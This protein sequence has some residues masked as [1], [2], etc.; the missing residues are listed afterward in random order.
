MWL[1]PA[2][3][4]QEPMRL[5]V[6]DVTLEIIRGDEV[7]ARFDIEIATTTQERSN[8]LMHRRDLPKDRGMLFVF[9]DEGI[10]YFWMENTPTS[11]DIIYAD[12]QG[13]IIRI[14]PNTTPFSRDPIPSVAPARY[15]LEIHA[16]LSASLD[17]RVD[18][19]IV[20]PIIT[21]D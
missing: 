13:R 15:A 11:L 3:L 20:H 21:G 6:D 4:A 5:P 2:A 18:D 9:D 14:A 16:G 7:V 12:S 19:V 17:V 10:R 8:G 1:V